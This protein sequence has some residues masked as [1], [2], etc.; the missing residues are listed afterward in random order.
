LIFLNDK[1]KNKT[2]DHKFN[3]KKVNYKNE[4][5]FLIVTSFF[6]LVEVFSSNVTRDIFYPILNSSQKTTK[7]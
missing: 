2:M 6:I 3:K 5:F 7:K 4:I 1:S